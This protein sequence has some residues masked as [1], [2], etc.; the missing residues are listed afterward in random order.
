M[1]LAGFL[2]QRRSLKSGEYDA[3]FSEVR[4]TRTITAV[5]GTNF[6]ITLAYLNEKNAGI[7]TD[8][9][10]RAKKVATVHSTTIP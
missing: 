2:R 1:Y 9:I 3:V 10:N 4:Q 8:M 7:M 6:T 5:K